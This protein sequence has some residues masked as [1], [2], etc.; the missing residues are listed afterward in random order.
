MTELTTPPT[1][2]TEPTPP[3][4][5]TAGA[6]PAGDAAKDS[7]EAAKY[8]RRLRET[9]TER[10]TLAERL[11]AMQ[12]R[13]AERVAIDVLADPADLFTIGGTDLAELLD[14]AGDVDPEKVRAAAAAVVA[15]RPGLGK[16][17]GGY[18]FGGGRRTSTPASGTPWTDAF[19][20]R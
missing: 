13:E 18:D 19:T 20:P 2:A 4:D 7:R 14:E 11:T 15:T 10:D 16:A 12:R 5:D 9:E 8:R 17:P 6:E 3:T 1:D